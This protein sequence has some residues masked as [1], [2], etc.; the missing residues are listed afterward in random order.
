[1]IVRT[2]FGINRNFDGNTASS[3]QVPVEI[4][5]IKTSATLSA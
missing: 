2:A 4:P 1:M 5:F 3:D